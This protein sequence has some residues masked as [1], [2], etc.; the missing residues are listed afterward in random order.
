M[1]TECAWCFR[2]ATHRMVYCA[3]YYGHLVN[4][5]LCDVHAGHPSFPRHEVFLVVETIPGGDPDG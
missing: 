5:F 2:R 4:N 3:T 1:H